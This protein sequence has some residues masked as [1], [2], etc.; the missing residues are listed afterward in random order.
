MNKLKGFTFI[1]LIL[2]IAIISTVLG[3]VI[4]FAISVIQGSAKSEIRDQVN[5]SASLIS[6]FISSRIRNASG[7]NLT[8]SNF[9]TNLAADPSARFTLDITGAGTPLVFSVLDGSLMLSRSGGAPVNLN[10]S[11]T[12]VTELIFT[13]NSSENISFSLTLTD[14]SSSTRQEYQSSINIVSSSQLRSR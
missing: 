7:I 6:A 13:D 12:R 5:T 4:P 1:E 8:G 9:G 2:Y 3:S 11:G 10:S 14:N